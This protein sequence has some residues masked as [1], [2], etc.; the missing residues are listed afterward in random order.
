M[1]NRRLPAH[2]E[3]ALAA[4][5]Q[6]PGGA[7]NHA[8]SAGQPWAGRDLS[9]DGNPLH[10]FDNDDGGVPAPYATAVAKLVAGEV[11]EVAVIRALAGIRVFVPVVAQLGGTDGREVSASHNH[12]G[13]DKEADMALVTLKAPDGR[14]ALPVFTS[15]ERLQQWHGE[16]RPVA[17]YAPR[18]A[19][20]AAAE[21]CELMVVDAGSDVT[22]VVRRPALWALAQ[23]QEWTPSYADEELGKLIAGLIAKDGAVLRVELGPGA[24]VSSRTGTG[25]VV[26]GGG[27]GPE[28]RLTIALRD[29]L[30]PE[31]VRSTVRDLQDRLQKQQKFVDRVDSLEIRLTR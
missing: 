23:Q 31:E 13:G 15:T 10:A 7:A 2:I 22:Y 1:S 3:A 17:V 29:G 11:G 19:L 28:L 6:R 27:A 20:A 4:P 9:G 26:S 12:H 14:A 5:P 18:A 21:K 24:G 8:D 25:T 16:A 30:S